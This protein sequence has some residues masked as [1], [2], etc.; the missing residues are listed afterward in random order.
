MLSLMLSVNGVTVGELKGFN[1]GARNGQANDE[2]S[3]RYRR[4]AQAGHARLSVNGT[5]WHRPEDG[6]EQLVAAM[7]NRVADAEVAGHLQ[8]KR[9]Q[10]A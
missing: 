8:S 10:T 1:L 4:M 5:L 7:L 2:Y 6:L 3:F 9:A